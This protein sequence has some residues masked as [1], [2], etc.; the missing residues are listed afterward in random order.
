MTTSKSA[1]ALI[2]AV[3]CMAGM[4][5]VESGEC[6]FDDDVV[7][8]IG[9]DSKV[10]VIPYA[11]EHNL[12]YFNSSA[13][14]GSVSEFWT[15]CTSKYED[16]FVNNCAW[17]NEA[18]KTGRTIVDIGPDPEGDHLGKFYHMELKEICTGRDDQEY[19]RTRTHYSSLIDCDDL[20]D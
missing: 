2:A 5:P 20:T 3:L 13:F 18:M 6:V 16:K 7:L 11:E 15:S 8:V 10:R 4:S 17:I 9:G 19:P 12:C 14:D 1:A